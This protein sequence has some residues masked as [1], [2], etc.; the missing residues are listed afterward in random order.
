MGEGTV[1]DIVENSGGND[2]GFVPPRDL[3]LPA[4][5]VG[6]VHC[7]EGVLKPGVVRPRIDK[8]GK[9]EL[10]DVPQPLYHREVNDRDYPGG[11]LDIAVDRVLDDLQT[12]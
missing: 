1:T 5:E 3:R 11:H 4:D 2:P 12:H 7:P 6:E 9:P 8:I 10:P